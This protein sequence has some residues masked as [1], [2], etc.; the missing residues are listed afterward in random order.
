[1]DRITR[2]KYQVVFSAVGSGWN[3]PPGI[4]GSPPLLLLCVFLCKGKRTRNKKCIVQWEHYTFQKF[5]FH[6]TYFGNLGICY[7]NHSFSFP[8]FPE[9][10]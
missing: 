7:Q 4:S 9:I 5:L 3:R 8:Y 2:I 10:R 6:Q 1:M